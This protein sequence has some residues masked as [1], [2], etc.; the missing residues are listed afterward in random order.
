MAACGKTEDFRP[1][2]AAGRLLVRAGRHGSS[3][4]ACD[5]AFETIIGE[6]CFPKQVL[7]AGR[8]MRRSAL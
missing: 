4:L 3:D 8:D 7:A 6:D 2:M 1:E 5:R